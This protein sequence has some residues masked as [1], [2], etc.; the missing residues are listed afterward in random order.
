MGV[1]AVNIGR[2]MAGEFHPHFL[3]N[4]SCCQGRRERVTQSV[5]GSLGE[6]PVPLPLNHHQIQTGTERDALK[7][8]RQSVFPSWALGHHR[9]AQGAC[10]E[11]LGDMMQVTQQPL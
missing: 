3:R 8:L 9:R 10:D 1:L 11:G 5:E 4:T 7:G 6:L 2:G